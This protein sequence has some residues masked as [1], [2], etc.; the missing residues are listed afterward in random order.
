MLNRAS[1]S[2]SRRTALAA[3]LVLAILFAGVFLA[4]R[5]G[6][7]INPTPSVPVGIWRVLP[8]PGK[9]ERGQ[10]V[11]ICPPPAAVFIEARDRGYIGAGHCPGGFEPMLKTV[12]ALGGD[13]IEQTPAG[14]LINGNAIAGSAA[15]AADGAGR[16]LPQP[17]R[18]SFTLRASE[19]FFLST[20]DARS[21]DSRYFGP[22]PLLVIEGLAVPVWV[23]TANW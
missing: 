10:V 22:L 16:P 9:I 13:V 6:Y 7:R 1:H 4:D 2:A 15:L 19:V 14:L 21:F 5:C 17:G 23:A 11:S 8:L 3:G 18:S 20:A 12:G